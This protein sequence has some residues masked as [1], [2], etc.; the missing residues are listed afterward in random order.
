MEDP[1]EFL[2]KVKSVSIAT[3]DNN[4][5]EVRIADVMLYEDD[6][7]YF[8]TARGK[9]YYKQLK[10]NPEI[11][12]VAMDE[13]YVTVRVKGKIKFVDNSFL[14]KMFDENPVMNHIYP[15]DT[16]EILEAFCLP[17]GVGEVFDL[18]TNTPKCERFAFGGETVSER[19]YKITDNCI[20]CGI[21]KDS[22]PTGAISEGNIY[23]ID[24][25]LCLEC[26][27]CYEKCPNDAIEE[28][29]EF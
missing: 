2:R 15:G 26:G 23:V 5:P 6:K 14:N 17:K 28:P 21:C 20:A 11:S 12:I 3:V 9:P 8:L 16:R 24:N 18:S 13:N 4:R 25:L 29:L 19:G 22:C 7:L 10:A 1:L 27:N